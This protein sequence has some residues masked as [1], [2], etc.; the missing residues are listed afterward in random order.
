[1]YDEIG[2]H[3][4]EMEVCDDQEL[5]MRTYLATKRAYIN[6]P[7]YIYRI[8]GDNVSIDHKNALIQQMTVQL[9]DQYIYKLTERRCE[10]EGLQIMELDEHTTIMEH[11]DIKD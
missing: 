3:N 9:Y 6:K 7:L 1:M 2:G 8:T 4:V 10:L 5:I 11:L